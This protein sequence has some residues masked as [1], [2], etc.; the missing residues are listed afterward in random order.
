MGPPAKIAAKHLGPLLALRAGER[1]MPAPPPEAAI[2]VA[3]E[4]DSGSGDWKDLQA[5]PRAS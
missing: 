3:R 1:S 5:E 4:F 2:S